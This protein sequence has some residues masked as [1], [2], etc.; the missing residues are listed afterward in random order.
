MDVDVVAV[1]A[2]TSRWCEDGMGHYFICQG[3]GAR[4]TRAQTSCVSCGE[5]FEAI[6]VACEI[7]SADKVKNSRCSDVFCL[8]I[9]F[10]WK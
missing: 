4:P 5:N 2:R 1:D 6:R 10:I 9:S 7:I 3:P 8:V